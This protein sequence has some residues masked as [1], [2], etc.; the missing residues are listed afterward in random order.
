LYNR[1][2][3]WKVAT[4]TAA[5]EFTVDSKIYDV[6]FLFF[7]KDFGSDWHFLTPQKVNKPTNRMVTCQASKLTGTLAMVPYSIMPSG[8]L[9]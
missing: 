7:F 9:G 1:I 4:F 2:S 3:T 6:R 5:R 8:E